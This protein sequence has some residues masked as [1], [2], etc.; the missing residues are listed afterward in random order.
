MFRP[1]RPERLRRYSS[2]RTP[3]Y[4]SLLYEALLLLLL[5]LP[6][7]ITTTTIQLSLNSLSQLLKSVFDVEPQELEPH[8]DIS[9]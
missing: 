9:V 2:P 1:R 7:T 8:V 4:G 5:L 3:L 6:T